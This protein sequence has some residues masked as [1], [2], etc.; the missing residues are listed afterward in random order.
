MSEPV[1]VGSLLRGSERG[2]ALV[3]KLARKYISK[4]YTTAG[5]FQR[6]LEDEGLT[7]RWEAY[8]RAKALGTLTDEVVR[9]APLAGGTV[10]TDAKREEIIL[11]ASDAFVDRVRS[12]ARVAK[13]SLK[14]VPGGRVERAR[15]EYE[16]RK[17]RWWND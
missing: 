8:K 7:D 17:D 10:L 6:H 13:P 4:G 15:K 14:V 3:E 16:A 12:E 9:V 2:W 1:L 5:H 11:R